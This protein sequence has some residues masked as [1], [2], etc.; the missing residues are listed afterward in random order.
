MKIPS[1]LLE[2]DQSSAP[3]KG[4]PGKR[5]ALG[6]ELILPAAS[7][8]GQLPERYGTKRLFLAL[9]DPEWVY[10]AWDFTREQ[11]QEANRTSNTGHL[12]LRLYR[13][14]LNKT[15][16]VESALHPESTHWFLHV[17]PGGR[18]KILAEL[19]C[20]TAT[21]NWK[22]LAT[23]NPVITP[24]EQVSGSTEAQFVTIKGQADTSFD[25]PVQTAERPAQTGAKSRSRSKERPS[26][27]QSQPTPFSPVIIPA[28]S[29]AGWT[30][31]QEEALT[32]VVS[33][34]EV[35]RH[36][37][38]SLELSEA[39]RA[40]QREILSSIQ[41]AEQRKREEE[42]GQAAISSPM[43]HPPTERGFWFNVNAELVV[44]GATDPKASVT[45]GGRPIRLR[46]DGSFSYRFSLPDGSYG[47][48]IQATSPDR[49]E[50]RKAILHFNRHSDYEGKVARHPQDPGLK[51]P[52][53]GNLD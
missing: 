52:H 3:D 9:R 44:Y 18:R 51:P 41:L 32:E 40:E 5:Y 27:A 36:W 37:A 34:V 28:Q 43:D 13:D 33:M 39:V 21:G 1:I 20:Y 23:S 14:R 24:P 12:T 11:L 30:S 2:G 22:Q 45:I 31:Q 17:G 16:I 15:P 53:P 19:G 46:K 38:S 42:A 6:Q 50:M 8:E 35:K 25:L 48:A 47:L 10:A 4:G 26:P 29:P 49:V 7:G